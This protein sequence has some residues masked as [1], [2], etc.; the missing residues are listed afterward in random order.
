MLITNSIMSY[1]NLLTH[2][3]RNWPT[4]LL[5]TSTST[6]DSPESQDAAILFASLTENSHHLTSAL[7]LL[8]AAVKYGIPLPPYFKTPPAVDFSPLWTKLSTD[9]QHE[10][11]RDRDRDEE[12]VYS[13]WAV[14]HIVGDMVNTA[15]GRMVVEVRELVGEVDFE[16]AIEE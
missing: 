13:A 1:I 8:S 16:S 14:M 3:T 11:G 10:H 7:T 5:P 12:A 6:P 4:L 2:S 9:I 15:L